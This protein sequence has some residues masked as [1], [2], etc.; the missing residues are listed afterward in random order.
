MSFEV[1]K[2]DFVKFK[3]DHPFVFW[4]LFFY[5]GF[6]ILYILIFLYFYANRSAAM[7]LNEIG[8]FLAGTFSPLAFL[9]LYLGYR[10]NSK[11]L[12]IQANQLAT[13]N[14]SL[15]KQSDELAESVKQQTELVLTAKEELKLTVT[16]HEQINRQQLIQ[17]QPYFHISDIRVKVTKVNETIDINI[18]FKITN[19][20]TMCRGLFFLLSLKEQD[21]RLLPENSTSFNLVDHNPTIAI[22]A[23][24]QA[25][26]SGVIGKDFNSQIYLHFCYSDAFDVVQEKTFKI[27]LSKQDSVTYI[28]DYYVSKSQKFN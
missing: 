3:Q 2:T 12:E 21:P 24:V 6:L 10:Q 17:A 5:L 22:P 28:Y 18:G 7:S 11:A 14:D 4:S 27:H 20:R 15:Q 1:M 25:T 19:S 16:Q 9:F 13:S 26:V 23:Y 8:D